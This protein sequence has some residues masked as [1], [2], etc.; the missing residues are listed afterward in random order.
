MILPSIVVVDDSEV[1]RYVARRV[2]RTT[3]LTERVVEL[4]DG[5]L[6]LALFDDPQRKAHECGSPP[7]PIL[8]LLD[9][10]MPRRSGF[11]VL[12]ELA[13][14]IADS[15]AGPTCFVVVM[16]TSSDNAGDRR[17]AFQYG[18]VKDYLVKPIDAPSLRAVVE[19]H[20]ANVAA[21]GA[22]PAAPDP[23]AGR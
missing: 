1:D 8:V 18:F 6:L 5:D 9:I 4:E 17:R 2:I 12:E 16:F 13:K 11:E 15:A 22:R 7:P 20:Y 10:N 21:P 23:P 3:R 19:K 14:R